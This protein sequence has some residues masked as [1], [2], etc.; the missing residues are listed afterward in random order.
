M[1]NMDS[2]FN[3]ARESKPFIPSTEVIDGLK[4]KLNATE[5]TNTHNTRRYTPSFPIFRTLRLWYLIGATT[6]VIIL[7]IVADG[8]TPNDSGQNIL[9]LKTE[10]FRIERVNQQRAAL[11]RY[12]GKS[13]ND[14]TQNVEVFF[15]KKQEQVNNAEIIPTLK[16]PREVLLKMG[17]R[18]EKEETIFEANVKGEGYLMI[19]LAKK[20]HALTIDDTPL[21]DIKFEAISHPLFVSD[22]KGVQRT[23]FAFGRDPMKLKASYFNQLIDDLV[24]IAVPH[25]SEE[26]DYLGI[27]W[28]KSTEELF[29]QLVQK[30]DIKE[31]SSTTLTKKDNTNQPTIRPLGNPFKGILN[32]EFSIP[33][34]DRV[35]I[36]LIS[37]EG[38]IVREL[39]PINQLEAGNHNASFELYDLQRGV[40]LLQ[41]ITSAGRVTKRI[42]K[43]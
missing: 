34:A 9:G 40:Y 11:I 42:I 1:S 13:E 16:V 38:N 8:L 37:I 30:P 3:Q 15:N 23:R 4:E 12:L 5:A 26:E 2:Y 7:I 36:H 22:M 43:E 21:P 32:V 18:F 19:S 41:M 29:D 6:V 25:P 28:F 35:A 20:T 10:D 17:F 39:M 27:F 24:P 33:E 14:S 31:N